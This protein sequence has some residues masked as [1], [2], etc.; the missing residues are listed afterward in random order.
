MTAISMSGQ[1]SILSKLRSGSGVLGIVMVVLIIALVPPI[2]DGGLKLFL[3]R[4]FDDNVP[5]GRLDP[6]ARGE[7]RLAQGA[8]HP[9]GPW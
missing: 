4:L 6:A 1:K 5:S 8:L 3:Q 9:H 2:V 7:H